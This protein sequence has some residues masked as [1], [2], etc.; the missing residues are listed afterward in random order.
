MGF[1]TTQYPTLSARVA[2]R[3]DTYIGDIT[4]DAEDALVT[5]MLEELLVLAPGPSGSSGANEKARERADGSV[6]GAFDE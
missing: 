3:V 6:P 4:Q 1:S 5:E 2:R